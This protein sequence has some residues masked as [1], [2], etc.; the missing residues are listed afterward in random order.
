VKPGISR[1]IGALIKRNFLCA[2]GWLTFRKVLRGFEDC[3]QRS[4]YTLVFPLGINNKGENVSGLP[5]M[6]K[7]GELLGSTVLNTHFSITSWVTARVKGG[8]P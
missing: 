4:W 7:V 2:Y 6:N 8:F 3:L 1:K 5:G